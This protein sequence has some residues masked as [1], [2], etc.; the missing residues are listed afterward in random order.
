VVVVVVVVVDVGGTVVV[1]VVVVDVGGTVV[2]VVVVVDV[3]GTVVVV[4]DGNVVVEFKFGTTVLGGAGIVVEGDGALGDSVVVVR[5]AMVVEVGENDGE[6]GAVDVG[7]S[8]GFCFASTSGTNAGILTATTRPSDNVA[9][10]ST[11]CSPGSRSL[12]TM[13]CA[14][15]VPS[16]LTGILLRRR[17][18]E[19]THTCASVTPCKPAP[20]SRT[21]APSDNTSRRPVANV[22]TLP[23]L[24]TT[25][26]WP[27]MSASF[28]V[29]CAAFSRTVTSRTFASD[30]S[31]EVV[32][33]D[34]H[35]IRNT[36]RTRPD[37]ASNVWMRGWV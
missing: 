8:N 17:G 35:P 34:E 32:F 26:T 33:E 5:G 7:A 28:Q 16:L 20:D 10:M 36:K 6:D 22:A 15:N 4:V 1:V 3:G 14:E 31:G 29:Y 12:G 9:L 27:D 30:E 11:V 19:N 25:S 23:L 2:V 13:I 18:V 24:S 37:T 21:V